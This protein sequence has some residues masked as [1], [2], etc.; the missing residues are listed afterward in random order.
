M[1]GSKYIS[2]EKDDILPHAPSL[3][4][5][6]GE[7]AFKDTDED[8]S[9]DSV[10]S[11][12]KK[13]DSQLVK[14]AQNK[15]KE[16]FRSLV[17]RYQNRAYSLAFSIMNNKQDAEDVVQESFVKAYLSIEKFKGQSSFYTWLYRIVRNMAIDVKRKRSREKS[18]QPDM[19]SFD[20][21]AEADLSVA[22]NAESQSPDYALLRKEKAR[23]IAAVLND[24][25]EEHRTVILLREIDGMDYSQI[26]KVTG[27]SKGTIMSRLHYA[28]KKLQQALS[29]LMSDKA[30]NT[31]LLLNKDKLKGVS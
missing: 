6:H 28:R 19:D 3:S 26:A 22:Y 18:T 23:R 21:E 20:I 7:E 24:I 27:V 9:G 16:A 30:Q 11:E 1:Y 31:D 13:D 4:V 10:M 12:E 15:D 25:S 8:S 5:V 17:E 29:D 2:K 14:R